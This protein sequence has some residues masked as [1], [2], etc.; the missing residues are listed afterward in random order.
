[1]FSE[2]Y[3]EKIEKCIFL[4]S[5]IFSIFSEGSKLDVMIRERT[6][7]LHDRGYMGRDLQDPANGKRIKD[8]NP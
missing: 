7:Q 5:F 6:Q 4:K 3:I 1:M 8:L 2:V